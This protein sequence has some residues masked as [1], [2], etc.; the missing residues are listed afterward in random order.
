LKLI[1]NATVVVSVNIARV[2]FEHF[3]F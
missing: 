1:T 2:I 3:L